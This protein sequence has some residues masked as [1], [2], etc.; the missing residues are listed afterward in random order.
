LKIKGKDINIS[1]KQTV[2]GVT[3][4][5]LIVTRTALLFLALVC[6]YVVMTNIKNE[7]SR[8]DELYSFE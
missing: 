3:A 6:L 7:A 2:N 4:A 5:M 8:I 1:N